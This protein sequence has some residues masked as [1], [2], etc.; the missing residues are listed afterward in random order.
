M[1]LLQH[2][3]GSEVHLVARVARN[4]DSLDIDLFLQTL[5]LRRQ[6]LASH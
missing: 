1:G 6:F 5:E 3:G 2:G 4:V